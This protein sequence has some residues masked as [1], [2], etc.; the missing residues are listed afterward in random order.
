MVGN[1]R[2]IFTLDSSGALTT[3]FTGNEIEGINNLN[4][5]KSH[6]DH[7]VPQIRK[8]SSPTGIVEAEFPNEATVRTIQ[9]YQRKLAA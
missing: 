5:S 9:T 1:T 8:L 6:P 4:L 2:L 3:T 7:I